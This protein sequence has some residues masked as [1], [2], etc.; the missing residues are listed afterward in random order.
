MRMSR[1]IGLSL[2][3]VSLLGTSGCSLYKRTVV[4]KKVVDGAKAFQEESLR[5][6]RG[7]SVRGLPLILS[8]KPRKQDWR[9]AF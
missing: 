6:R 5:T 3:I 8:L 2:V 4:Q 7:F 1:F 9:S